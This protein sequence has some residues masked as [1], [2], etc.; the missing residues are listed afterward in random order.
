[1]EYLLAGILLQ[2]VRRVVFLFALPINRVKAEHVVQGIP[3][4]L[5]IRGLG[6]SNWILC[7]YADPRGECY[8]C[9]VAVLSVLWTSYKLTFVNT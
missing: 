2:N 9:P 7:I 3:L 1:M 6:C 8:C 5:F 4:W